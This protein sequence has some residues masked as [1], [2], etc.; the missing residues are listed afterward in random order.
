MN[1]P[2]PKPL[3]GPGTASSHL[4]GA[5]DGA[6]PE[7]N[8]ILARMVN[9]SSEALKSETVEKAAQLIANR[10]HTIVKSERVVV[11][12]L[13]GRTAV[14]KR[15]YCI[16]GDIEPSQD[17]PFSEAVQDLRRRFGKETD[18]R[19]VTTETFPDD[20]VTAQLKDVLGAMGGTTILWVPIPGPDGGEPR[21]ALW[22]E[23][24]GRKTWGE[25]DMRLMRHMMVFV[26]HALGGAVKPEHKAVG[27]KWKQRLKSYWLWAIM[28]CLSFMPVQARVSA[29][30]QVV[31]DQP[32]YVFAPFDGIIEQLRVKPGEWVKSGD[33]LFRYDT[34]VLEKQ[35]EEAKRGGLAVARAEL[36]R[37]EGAAVLDEEARA[38]LP[39]QKLEVQRR[40]AEVAF[41]ERQ[42]ELSEVKSEK[43]GMV[44]LDDPD[45]L[46][47]AF[48]QTGQ[49]VLRVADPNR[50]RIRVMMPVADV[51]L[52]KDGVNMDVRLDS[53]PLRTFHARVTRVAY[54]VTLSDERVP[55]VMIEAEWK[56][57]SD[58]V[59]PGQRGTATIE[60]P[61]ILF[62]VQFL[63]KQLIQLR[64]FFG[65]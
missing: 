19:V 5:G 12:P 47:G 27:N 14:S 60:G 38:R 56:D 48:V 37:L 9:L 51:G 6:K 43:E 10:L 31:P 49:M 32:Y 3:P 42:M 2:L 26:S 1:Q 24:W 59:T 64:N 28:L 33:P 15:I 40:Q 36:A 58:R 57:T 4:G 61:R 41:L 39:V 55:S 29:P 62:A 54:D 13:A 30:F 45:A 18:F 44:V 25:E 53:D 22:L 52:V 50:T 21:F 34:R 16:S 46:I 7:V 65:I 63:R 11:V 35:L 17:N 23:R 8:T 20:Q